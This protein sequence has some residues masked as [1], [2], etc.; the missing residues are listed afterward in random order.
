M[1]RRAL[2]ALTLAAALLSGCA[3]SP[4]SS[5]PSAPAPETSAVSGGEGSATGGGTEG[6]TA[7]TSVSSSS[8][9]PVSSSSSSSSSSLSSSPSSSATSGRPGAFRALSP[10]SGQEADTASPSF[11]WSSAGEGA[12]YT[13]TLEIYKDGG[14]RR[15]ET[16]ENLTGTSWRPSS[17]LNDNTIYRWR[18]EASLGGTSRP[19]GGMQGGQ[20]VFMSKRDYKTHPANIGRDYAF[21]GKITEAVL[22]NYL[23][24]AM[25]LSWLDCPSPLAGDDKRMILNTGAKYIGRSC[26]P[27][28]MGDWEYARMIQFKQDIAA[29]HAEDPDIIVEACIFE[30][31][32][33][34][35]EK[36]A[37]PAYV[38][39]AFGQPVQNRCFDYEAMLYPDG[40]YINHWGEGGSVPDIT[41]L[42]TQM[43]FYYRSCEFIKAGFEGLHYGQVLLMGENDRSSGYACWKKV[44][45]LTRAFAKQNARR[46]MVLINAHTSGMKDSSGHL[47]FDFHSFPLRLRTPAGST[48]HAPTEQNPQ[49]TV[50]QKGWHDSLYGKSLG[51]ITPSGYVTDSSPYFVELDNY[52]G[53]QTGGAPSNRPGI[54]FFP[55]GYDEISWFANQPASYRAEWL[56]STRDAIRA[57]D[58]KGHLE[59]PG[60]RPAWLNS[61][62]SMGWYYANST[63]FTSYGFGDEEAIRSAFIRDNQR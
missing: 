23:D 50:I 25:I 21:D 49:V 53:T 11:Q 7:G 52:G 9:G 60:S 26:I 45:D 41:R 47:F 51:G 18:V 39:E 35:I 19:A 58:P 28:Q 24:R 56:A 33:T 8:G 38:F 61:S 6:T 46:H 62:G 1:K 20:I 17:P 63:L 16:A 12:R 37:I 44:L 29:L 43:W 40:R 30:T 57:L 5:A 36:M 10:L 55:W 14:F 27:W 59:M 34:S 2:A 3:S 15:V 48:A 22:E 42:E 54:D 13:L 31:T 4:S 32:W